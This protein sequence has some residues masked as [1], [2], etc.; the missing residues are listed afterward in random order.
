ME[1][2]YKYMWEKCFNKIADI[3]FKLFDVKN[4]KMNISIF[5]FDLWTP[6]YANL[7]II[8]TLSDDAKAE[9]SI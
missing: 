5:H 6:K 8:K 1:K 7:L 3:R 2:K 4:M 9:S